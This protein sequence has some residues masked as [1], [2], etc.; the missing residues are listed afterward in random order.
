M[1]VNSSFDSVAVDELTLSHFDEYDVL[2]SSSPLYS[3]PSSEFLEVNKITD[4][5]YRRMS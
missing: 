1:D 3:S 4:L 2:I 5:V